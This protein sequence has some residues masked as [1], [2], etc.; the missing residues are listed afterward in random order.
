MQSFIS[1]HKK[2]IIGAIIFHTALAILLFTFKFSTPL[3][4]PAEQGILINFGNSETGLGETEPAGEPVEQ[5]TSSPPAQ[6]KQA[7]QGEEEV[8]TQDFEEAPVI[9]QEK[10]EKIPEK[11]DVETTPIEEQTTKEEVNEKKEEEKEPTIDPKA[12][13]QGKKDT[14]KTSDG[15]GV[16]Y[17]KNNQ[18]SPSGSPDSD[19]YTQ[20]NSSGEGG[21]S[22]NLS[23][24]NPQHL[25]KPEYN[26]QK[27]GVVVVAVTVNRDGNVVQANAGV[28]GSTTL[29]DYLLK[30]AKNAALNSN[31]DK[32]PDGPAFQKGTITYHFKMY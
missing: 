16:T 8:I 29:D 6:Q 19:N 26:Y 10:K 22:Y 15:E 4:L 27:E 1:K 17:G 30:M 31:F 3:P 7:D 13:Y 20:G 5:L 24:R 2:G 12:L 11:K 18:G 28:K 23:G 9:E 21:I 32:N 25:A 14:E